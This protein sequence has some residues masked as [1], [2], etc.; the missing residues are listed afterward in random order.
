[1]LNGM[2]KRGWLLVCLLVISS[3]IMAQDSAYSLQECVNLALENNLSIQ[4]SKLDKQTSEIGLA[5]SKMNRYPSLNLSSSY[6]S[7]WGRS[8]DPTTNSFISQ[9][10]N[11][12][13]LGGNS[14]VTLFNGFQITNALKQSKVSLEVA[15]ADLESSK[16]NVSLSVITLYLNT[17]FN[18]ELVGNANFQLNS[19]TEQLE[20]TKTLVDA[21]ALPITNLLDLQAQQASNE[22]NLINAENNYNFALLQLKQSLLIPAGDAFEIEVP[23]IQIENENA[24]D[25]DAGQVYKTA[26]ENQPQIKSADLRIKESELGYDI[27]K[28]GYMPSL[29][30]NGSFRTNYSSFA[31][32]ARPIFS[33]DKI[34]VPIEIGYLQN[35]PTDRVFTDAEFPVILETDPDFTLPEQFDANL[36]KSLSINLSIPVFNNWRT[37]SD[38]QRSMINQKR[39]QINAQETR[40]QLRQTIETSTNDLLAASKSFTASEKQVKALEESFRIIENQYN[41]GA[42]NFVDFQVSANN[43]FIAKSDLV[44]AKYDY[45]FKRK[46]LDFYLG[47]PL[48][49]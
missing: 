28:S 41:L 45:I 7:N 15:N 42:V 5:Q 1:M 49:F 17:I 46:V 39:A 13:G 11:S 21:G 12:S 6:G 26:L 48:S 36:S 3:Q 32:R 29:T 2:I 35:T 23:N 16:N 37:R 30:L 40:N 31:D 22:V 4:R 14:S 10:I 47:K 38:V 8:I 20:R 19:T 25:P 34:I 27:A 9:K 43:L 33:G 18:K 24:V 44:R